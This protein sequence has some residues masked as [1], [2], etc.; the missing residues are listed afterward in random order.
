MRELDDDA[1]LWR[2]D[3][4]RYGWVLPKP[5]AWPL[6]LPV[7][8]HIRAAWNAYWIEQHY[9]HGLGSIGLRTGYDEW[10]LY[11]IWRGWA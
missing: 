5:A 11:A 7:I 4:D 1:K 10:A 2:E 9:R 6:R 3:G 8:R